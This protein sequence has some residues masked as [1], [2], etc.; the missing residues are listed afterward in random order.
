MGI[1][2]GRVTTSEGAFEVPVVVAASGWRAALGSSRNPGLVP[3]EA[4]SLGVELRLPVRDEGLHFWVLPE[5]IGCGVTWLFPACTHS[6]AGIACY[7]GKGGLKRP[8]EEFLDDC[9]SAGSL[10]GASSP[11][12]SGT[13]WRA[14]SSWWEETRP[15]S[16]FV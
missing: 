3:V 7:R 9:V 8:L 13:R 15:A 16:A 4:R 1:E 10:H 14:R 12:G 11:R 5:Q 6:R 2:D